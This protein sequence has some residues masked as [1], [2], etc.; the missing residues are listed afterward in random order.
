MNEQYALTCKLKKYDNKIYINALNINSDSTNLSVYGDIS[1]SNIDIF[2]NGI[3]ENNSDILSIVNLEHSISLK[4][5]IALKNSVI[6]YKADVLF[7]E[8][9]FTF[10]NLES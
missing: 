8:E 2:I 7:N 6:N 5:N 10:K 1:G 9:M 3:V 4:S